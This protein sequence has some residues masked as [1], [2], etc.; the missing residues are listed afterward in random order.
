MRPTVVTLTP[1]AS[2]EDMGLIL[3]IGLLIAP[4]AIA[5]LIT[6]EFRHMLLVAVLV[7]TA[8]LTFGVYLSFWLGSDPGPTVILVMTALFVL[9]FVYRLIRTART[10]ARSGA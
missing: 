9:A 4:G 6:R 1:V 5:F 7:S 3:A 2:W 10:E 8:S